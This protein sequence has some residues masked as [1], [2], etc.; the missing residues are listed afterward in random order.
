MIEAR[1]LVVRC[2]AQRGGV[3][4]ICLL[5]D[6]DPVGAACAL[7]VCLDMASDGLC[8]HEKLSDQTGRFTLLPAG[9][10]LLGTMGN[11]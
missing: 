7:I 2:M 6:D 1:R 3:L 11:A 9:W 8:T 5:D 10:T 4:E